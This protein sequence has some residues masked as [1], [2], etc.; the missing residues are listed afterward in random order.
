MAKTKN[1]KFKASVKVMNSYD[2][3]HFEFT[4]S[5]D[6]AKTKKEINEMRKEAQRLVDEAIRQYRK[7]KEM[8]AKRDSLGYERENLEREVKA[9]KENVPHNEWTPDQ[10][11]KVKHLT[12]KDYWS[13]YDYDYEDEEE[14]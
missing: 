14:S 5:S 12:D 9:I 8:I 10:K 13:R 4:L 3:G 7:A 6:Q 2:Y 1:S 11:A